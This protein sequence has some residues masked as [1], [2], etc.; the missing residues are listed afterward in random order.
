M[1]ARFDGQLVSGQLVDVPLHTIES[2][3]SRGGSARHFVADCPRRDCA[4]TLDEC[5]RCEQLASIALDGHRS[6]I[7]CRGSAEDPL[8]AS[9]SEPSA[10]SLPTPRWS[11]ARVGDVMTRDVICVRPDASVARAREVLVEHGISGMPVVGL[12]DEPL[13]MVSQCDLVRRSRRDCDGKRIDEIMT[14]LVFSLPESASVAL[15]AE[16]MAC[17][18]VDRI[19]IVSVDGSV[20]GILSALDVA[21]WIADCSATPAA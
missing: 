17:E 10:P 19:P 21:R 11:D 1:S 20:V 2:F 7:R 9:A 18:R 6:I 15:A 8:P 16:L 3:D 5:S 14:P 12:Y 13:G 4:V